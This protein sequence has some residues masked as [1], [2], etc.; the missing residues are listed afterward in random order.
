MSVP[1]LIAGNYQFMSSDIYAIQR[2]EELHSHEP[3][4]VVVC[5][6]DSRVPPEIIFNEQSSALK[7]GR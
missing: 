1:S 6:S 2:E 7:S 5:C 3:C 4:Y